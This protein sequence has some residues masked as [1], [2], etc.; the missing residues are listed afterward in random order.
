MRKHVP[1]PCP[2]YYRGEHIEGRG[3][4]VNFV[5]PSTRSVNVSH[6]IAFIGN[7]WQQGET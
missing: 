5:I 2:I 4:T 1:L 3:G 7:F 6:H